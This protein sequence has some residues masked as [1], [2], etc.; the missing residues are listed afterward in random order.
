MILTRAEYLASIESLLP[1][2]STQEISPLDLRT[3]L[4]NLVDSVPSFLAGTTI[5]TV[6]FRTPDIRTTIGGSLALTGMDLNGRS[7]VDNSAFGFAA[8]RNNYHGWY[9]T[10]VGSYALGCNLYGRGNTAVGFQALVGNVVGSGNVGIGNYALNNNRRGDFNIAIGHGAGWYHGPED[11]YTFSLGSIPVSSGDL[12]DVDQPV[13]SG[14]APL[15]YGDLNVNSHRLAVGTN[16]LHNHGMVQVSGAVTPSLS[17]QFDLGKGQVP[18]KSINENVHF[19]GGLVGVGGQPSGIDDAKMTVYGDLVPSRDK[20]YALGHP[21][22]RW[23]GYFNDVIIS[24]QIIANDIS[25]NTITNCLYECKTLHLATSGFCDPEGDGFH[26]DAVCGFLNDEGLDG[27]G[28][29]VHSSGT[30]YRR[31]YH[32]L[33]R[34]P[35]PNLNCLPATN[36]YTR[37]RWESNI[38]VETVN[39]A[40]FIGQR[41][42]GRYDTGM[43]I[44][45]GCMGVFIEPSDIDR[46]RLVVAQEPQFVAQYPTLQDAN[47]I[48]NSGG[49]DYTVM[50]GTPESGVKVIQ[51]FAS[52]ITSGSTKRGFSVVYHD[53]MDQE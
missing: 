25:Y 45:S 12:C 43:T 8:L 24:G 42:H 21:E 29:E 46:Q 22:L 41:L 39:G 44:E 33:Y 5:D 49:N 35:D 16:V 18:W 40:S 28:F 37:S 51:E 9:N 30:T 23:D 13:Y 4:T 27:A 34:F 7:S 32:F 15:L 1:D 6:N 14:E 31:D 48:A 19:S 26:N 3:S 38:S 17:G 52:R 11:N 20:R 47:F 50:Y 10:A 53:E 36:S 2:N